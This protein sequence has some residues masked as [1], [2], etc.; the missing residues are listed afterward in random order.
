MLNKQ[1]MLINYFN[2]HQKKLLNKQPI[3]GKQR[4]TI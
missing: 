3:P 2:D 4:E 1:N